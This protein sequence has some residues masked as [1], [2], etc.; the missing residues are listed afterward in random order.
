MAFLAA[1]TTKPDDRFI[2]PF[3]VMVIIIAAMP[4]IFAT[5]TWDHS[6]QSSVQAV[7]RRLAFPVILAEIA[8]VVLALKSGMTLNRVADTWPRPVRA[9]ILIVLAVIM[10]TE[11]L[12]PFSTPYSMERTLF[13]LVHIAFG[14]SVWHLV[15]RS[16]A[17]VDLFWPIILIGLIAYIGTL[18]LYIYAINDEPTFNWLNVGLG[19]THVRH[20][21]VYSAIGTSIAWGLLLPRHQ[22]L[23]AL[24]LAAA[25]ICLA[26]TFWSGTRGSLLALFAALVVAVAAFPVA[27]SP[28]WFSEIFLSAGV[29]ALLSLLHQ[30]PN[31]FYGLS[32]IIGSSETSEGLEKLSSGRTTMWL[33]AADLSL[34]N[35]VFGIGESRFRLLSESAVG[36]YNH[37]HNFIL[38]FCLQWGI[39]TTLLVLGIFG[40]MMVRGYQRARGMGE[41]AIPAVLIILSLTI[42]ASID[43]AFYYPYP[44]AMTAVAFA[45]LFG[46][47]EILSQNP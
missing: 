35:P 39:P 27:R 23:K 41:I 21:G 11:F 36:F 30:P 12:L 43:G 25:S 42:L 18:A 31:P 34:K 4:V 40:L 9:A 14:L 8:V 47:R 16:T 37:P 32:R 10:G 3:L 44:I 7:L 26:L 38:Q 33:D 29:A 20:F 5:S 28:K 1:A 17:H 13:Y 22:K 46:G 45:Y 24:Y 2:S 19:V 15:S 6:L